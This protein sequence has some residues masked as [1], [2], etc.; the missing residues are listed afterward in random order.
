[1]KKSS[2]IHYSERALHNISDEIITLANAE[3][4][5]AHANSISIRKAGNDA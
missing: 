3:G 4:L 1:M 5:T 2:I